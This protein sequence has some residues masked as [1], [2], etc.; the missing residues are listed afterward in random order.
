MKLFDKLH[1]IR[2]MY[3]QERNQIVYVNRFC[4]YILYAKS[5]ENKLNDD[6]YIN[7]TPR[8]LQHREPVNE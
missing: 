1:T 7:F 6:I 3:I 4:N 8:E 2:T 5:C